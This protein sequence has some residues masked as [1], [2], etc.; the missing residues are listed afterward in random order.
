MKKL[1]FSIAVILTASVST[2]AQNVVRDANGNF[3]PVQKAKT[4]AQQTQYTFTTKQGEIFP[5]Y[6]SEN[7]KYYVIR[8]SKKTGK[9]YRYYL[10]T[11]GKNDGE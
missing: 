1:I 7:G 10:T 6:V 9:E 8:V 11:E 4:E 2:F 3:L 5:V